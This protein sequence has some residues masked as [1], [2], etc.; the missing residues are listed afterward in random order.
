[1]LRQGFRLLNR[2]MRLMWR[3]GLG[4]W[5]NS[6]PGVLGR[7]LVIVHTG[8]KSGQRRTTPVNYAEIDGAVYVTA[9]FG[10]ISDWYRN[11]KANPELEVWMPD[12][13]WAGRAEEMTG[14]EGALDKMRQVLIGSG[15]VAP[16]MGVNPHTMPDKALAEAT[17]DY[18]L[19]RIDRLEAR[20][21]P[22]GPG[23]LAWVWPIATTVLVQLLV[24]SLS[25][26]GRKK[27]KST[28]HCRD[29]EN[30]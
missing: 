25:R 18:R 26:R 6:W 7:F 16:L 3:L 10:A 21:G 1:M 4:R 9:G 29:A 19:L 15:F 14:T 17:K 22:G 23:D 8:R 2:F 11:L 5:L 12:G 30:N 28:D 24:M 20:T 27:M 13:W